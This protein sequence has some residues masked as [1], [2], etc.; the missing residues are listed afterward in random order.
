MCCDLSRLL[1]AKLRDGLVFRCVSLFVCDALACSLTARLFLLDL[2]G[3]HVGCRVV[4]TALVVDLQ[5]FSF[6]GAAAVDLSAAQ[7]RVAS[8]RFDPWGYLSLDLALA[9][10]SF[11]RSC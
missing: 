5:L 11:D 1:E 3:W 8:L 10:T 2:I 4:D 6:V 9:V 7:R